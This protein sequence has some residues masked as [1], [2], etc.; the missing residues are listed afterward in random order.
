MSS[1]AYREAYSSMTEKQRDIMHDLWMKAENHDG[2]AWNMYCDIEDAVAG[3]VKEQIASAKPD[4]TDISVGNMVSKDAVLD[5]IHKYM[6]EPDYTIGLLHDR[7]C[8]MPP[9][10]P[11]I[12]H[13]KDCKYNPNPPECGNAA[14]VLFYGMTDQMSFCHH[15]ERR[16]RE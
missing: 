14:C 6:E 10:Q 16:E 3:I 2:H 4:V 5:E 7:V 1:K 15:G 9:A 12:I 13:C 8:E 11:E